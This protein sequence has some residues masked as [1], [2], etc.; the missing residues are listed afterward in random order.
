MYLFVETVLY[1]SLWPTLP[2]FMGRE[3]LSNDVYFHIYPVRRSKC[4]FYY[5]QV[6]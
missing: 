6:V 1:L 4:S 5:L 3:V 2:S